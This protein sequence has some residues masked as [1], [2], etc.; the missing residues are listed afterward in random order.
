MSEHKQLAPKPIKLANALLHISITSAIAS[1]MEIVVTEHRAIEPLGAGPISSSRKGMFNFYPTL[2]PEATL[3]SSLSKSVPVSSK[4]SVTV[5][6]KT[7]SVSSK[8]TSVSSKGTPASSKTTSVSS[9]PPP[10]SSTASVFSSKIKLFN[11][12]PTLVSA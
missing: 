8:T 10:V 4:T 12:Y 5:S 6:S 11:F 2:A 9:K 3:L 1:G 7:S